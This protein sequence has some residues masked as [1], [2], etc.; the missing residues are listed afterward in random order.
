M[1]KEYSKEKPT[2]EEHRY[3]VKEVV[4]NGTMEDLTMFYVC[5]YSKNLSKLNNCDFY[6]KTSGGF[7]DID[8]EYGYFVI[9]QTK[10]NKLYWLDLTEADKEW[11]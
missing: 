4:S 3:L 10:F 11:S 9:D 5:G 1:W 2:E 8:S 6:R 7:Y